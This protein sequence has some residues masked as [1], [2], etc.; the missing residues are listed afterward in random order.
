MIS[1][2]EVEGKMAHEGQKDEG[3]AGRKN[4]TSQVE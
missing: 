4:T 1:K 2:Q 3:G